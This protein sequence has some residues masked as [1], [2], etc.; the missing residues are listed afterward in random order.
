MTREKAIEILEMMRYP[1]PWEPKLTKDAEEALD[2]AI[3]AL[4][5]NKDG[6]SKWNYL[7]NNNNAGAP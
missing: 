7:H 6:E 2:M 1:E 5:D 4:R 3:D